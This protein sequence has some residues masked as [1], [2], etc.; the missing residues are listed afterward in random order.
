MNSINVVCVET[1][2]ACGW[3]K[4]R[5]MWKSRLNTHFEN[6]AKARIHKLGKG[7]QFQEN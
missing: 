2:R 3:H 6:K 4:K 1:T 5:R 7:R